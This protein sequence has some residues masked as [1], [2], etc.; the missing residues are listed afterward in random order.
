MYKRQAQQ[1]G[2]FYSLVTT[3][4]GETVVNDLVIEALGYKPY[5]VPSFTVS[6]R[7]VYG[8]G[9]IA[10]EPEDGDIIRLPGHTPFTPEEGKGG[11]AGFV[12][13]Y[14]TKMPIP[15]FSISF[16]YQG[17]LYDNF[18]YTFPPTVEGILAVSYTHLD[19]YKRQS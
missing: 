6:E 2:E 18:H 1:L 12:Y 13:D 10:L 17:R 3:N 7:S 11:F 4:G 14:V 8:L 16:T 19:V 15:N 9:T 5:K